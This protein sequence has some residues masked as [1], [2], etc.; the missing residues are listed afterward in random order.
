MNKGTLGFIKFSEYA[1]SRGY[2]RALAGDYAYMNK[3]GK[4]LRL[5][6][7]GD[8][9]LKIWDEVGRCFVFVEV[10]YNPENKP[11]R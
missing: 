5:K 7:F 6:S 4:I 3:T 11:S 9:K 10:E 1:K 2:T 8:N